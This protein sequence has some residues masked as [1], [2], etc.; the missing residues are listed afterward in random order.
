MDET[1]DI[2]SEVNDKKE[3]VGQSSFDLAS[4]NPDVR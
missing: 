4:D 1:L 2:K 3:Y